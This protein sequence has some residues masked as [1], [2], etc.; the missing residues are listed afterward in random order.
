MQPSRA[1][2]RGTRA[3]VAVLAL[4]RWMDASTVVD[5]SLMVESALAVSV[6]HVGS[7]ERT[8][9]GLDTLTKLGSGFCCGPMPDRTFFGIATAQTEM[10]SRLDAGRGEV[11]DTPKASAFA[12]TDHA[13]LEG[14]AMAT[15]VLSY[16]VQVVQVLSLPGSFTLPPLPVDVS[17]VG[18]A[19]VENSDPFTSA[20]AGG[21]ARFFGGTVPD[22]V[23]PGAST[24]SGPVITD[25][26]EDRRFHV[27]AGGTVPV[28]L[29]AFAR[30]Q[31]H[32]T[33]GSARAEASMDPIFSFNQEAFD[34]IARAQG[35]ATFEL[36]RH[37]AF[38]QSPLL[39]ASEI[40]EPTPMILVA[41]GLLLLGVAR[42]R[43]IRATQHGHGEP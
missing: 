2:L 10:V 32:G 35:F 17:V 6:T 16:E 22:V 37:F 25:V 14:L 21:F 31:G 23:L 26:V 30:A 39:A 9:S 19:E 11:V 34:E 1:A 13:F 29:A 24:V 43:R 36:D 4:A 8:V 3:A 7:A 18:F 5:P 28:I 38:A 42:R 40:P 20:T 33:L 27:R 15:A 41:A 12:R